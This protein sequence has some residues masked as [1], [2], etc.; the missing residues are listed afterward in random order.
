MYELDG[1]T[2]SAQDILSAARRNNMSFE[3]AIQKLMDQGL[4]N[5]KSQLEEF[6]I[7]EAKLKGQE[8]QQRQQEQIDIVQEALPFM[9][10]FVQR[11]TAQGA[12]F[13]I[14]QLEGAVN[15]KEAFEIQLRVLA[16]EDFDDIKKENIFGADP[17]A[18]IDNEE[19]RERY[20]KLKQKALD[21]GT[22]KKFTEAYPTYADF[23]KSKDMEDMIS[24]TKK[25]L[26]EYTTQHYD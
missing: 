10:G 17:S 3:D 25:I 18:T 15:A 4:I 23:A 2:F 14:R 12:N 5:E 26:Y 16:G 6:Y 1:Q 11:W 13:F 19:Y 8:Q 21:K 24:S 22:I 7:E 9:P 20:E